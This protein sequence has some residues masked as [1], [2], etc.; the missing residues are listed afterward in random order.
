MG[1]ADGCDSVFDCHLRTGIGF[2]GFGLRDFTDDQFNRLRLGHL[3]RRAHQGYRLL[4]L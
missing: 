1:S 2:L 3:R 4:L